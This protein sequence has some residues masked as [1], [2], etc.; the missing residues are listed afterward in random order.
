MVSRKFPSGAILL[1][2]QS[3]ACSEMP[4]EHLTPQTAF[5]A[6]DIIAMHRSPDRDG[7]CPLTPGFGC[8]FSEPRERP[9]DGRDQFSELVGPDLVSSN[10]RGDDVSRQFS[11]E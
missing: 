6:N 10:I 9:I 3:M 1:H 11:I 8:G 5:Q 2:G 7:S 4:S